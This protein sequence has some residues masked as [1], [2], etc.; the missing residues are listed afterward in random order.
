MSALKSVG[1]H[2]RKI[3]ILLLVGSTG[4]AVT[5]ILSF[6]KL[7][8]KVKFPIIYVLLTHSNTVN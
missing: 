3:F 2:F 4:R 5:K 7:R 6:R 8:T 1:T